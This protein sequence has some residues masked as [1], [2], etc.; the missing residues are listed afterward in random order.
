MLL[1]TSASRAGA[2]S[3]G[4]GRAGGPADDPQ[5][6]G[7][8]DPVRV[9]ARGG[10]GGADQGADRVVGQQVTPQLLLG[11]GRGARAQ[12]LARAAQRGLELGVACLVLPEL[13]V[14]LRE[15]GGAGLPRVG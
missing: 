1:M 13:V 9:N 12:H 7:E 5:R 6:A 10:G 15:L 11:Q 8:L 14:S 3:G 4:K 2:R